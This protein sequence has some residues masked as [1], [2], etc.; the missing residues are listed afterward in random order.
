V[1]AVAAVVA[2]LLLVLAHPFAV[3]LLFLPWVSLG[4]RAP[5]QPWVVALLRRLV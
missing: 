3:A 5:P 4:V 2:V 1:V